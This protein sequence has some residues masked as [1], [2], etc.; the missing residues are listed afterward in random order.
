MHI[1]SH[2]LFGCDSD[3]ALPT[4][5]PLPNLPLRLAYSLRTQ[6][7]FLVHDRLEY[8]V[9]QKAED[10]LDV[11]SSSLPI[12]KIRA[13]PIFRA[14]V[15]NCVSR[16]GGEPGGE[17]RYLR[18]EDVLYRLHRSNVWGERLYEA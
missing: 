10:L 17:K 11:L 5:P 16:R 18:P 15:T 13:R 8:P 6:R 7:V 12:S 2:R 3:Q 1:P 14:H 9:R 4:R